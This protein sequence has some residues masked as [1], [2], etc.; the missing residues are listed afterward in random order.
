MS[1]ISPQD[2]GAVSLISEGMAPIPYGNRIHD[3][4]SPGLDR[5]TVAKVVGLTPHEH[6]NHAIVL[7]G[8]AKSHFPPQGSGFQK[9]RPHSDAFYFCLPL[10]HSGESQPPHKTVNLLF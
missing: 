5:G 9:W 7:K 10:E 2:I 4:Y 1:A 3:E 6:V 8:V